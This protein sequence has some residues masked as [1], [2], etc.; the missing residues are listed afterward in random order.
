[1]DEA[2]VL[3]DKG[4]FRWRNLM[5]VAQHARQRLMLTRTPLQNDL[6]ELWSL[7]E[8]M[9]PD[10]FAT[11]DVDLKKL[12]N[13]EDH[14]LILRIKSILGPFILRCLKSD[15]MQQLVPKIQHVNFVVMDSE[16]SRAYNHAIEEYRAACQ[17]RSAKSKV[18]FSNNVVGLIPKRQ[19]S[20]YFMQFRK[21]ANHPLLIRR[22]YSDN[23]VDRIARL[24]YPRGPFG[25]ECSLERATQ[26]LKEYNDFAIHQ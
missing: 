8:F 21:I 18:K 25:F 4:S 7:L 22:I 10:I 17:A 5:A 1:M 16:Q 15:V 11:G 20:N 9:M 19:I 3:K 12:L 14:G 26:K 24:L 2:H 13:E 23:D 6:H